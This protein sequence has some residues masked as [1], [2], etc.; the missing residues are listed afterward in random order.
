MP[1]ERVTA[2]QFRET[3]RRE[4]LSRADDYDVGFGPIR[5]IVIDPVASVLEQQNDRIREVSL[6]ISLLNPD[7]LDD[8]DVDAFVANEGLRRIQGSRAVTN[9]TFF[10]TTVD[11]SGP[12][13]VVQQGY[14][15]ATRPDQQTGETITFVTTE[16]ATLVVA[17]ASSFFNIDTQRFELTVPARATVGGTIGNVAS[18]RI[19]R[20]LRPLVGFAGVTNVR[21]ST[22]GRGRETNR[23][24]IERYLLTVRGTDISTAT[25]VQRFIRNRFPTVTDT[26]VVF[27]N[28]PLLTRA[29][30]TTGAV[31]VY[32]Q[33]SQ[34][35]TRTEIVEFVGL[36]Q[37]IP[38]SFPPVQSVVSVTS[39]ATTY[40]EG[41]DFVVV[42]DTT[43]NSGSTRGSDGIR[44]LSTASSPPAGGDAVT[45]VYASNQ[46]VRDIQNL[47]DDDDQRVFGRDLLVRRGQDVPVIIEARLRVEA[48]FN[49]S[50]VTGAVQSALLD[51]VNGLQFGANVEESDLQGEVRR[52]TGVDNFLIDRL[53]RSSVATGAAD[54]VINDNEFASL[55]AANITITQI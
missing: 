33:G 21:P 47:L 4:I 49:G 30:A 9:L 13:I 3:L 25:G 8:E 23:Q 53:V 15:V 29:D 28:N 12:D 52:V 16:P 10:T 39:G 1:V 37:F 24:L 17:S 26:A 43:D 7:S 51:F 22:G 42:Q 11:T 45:V 32:I 31:D 19:Q 46:L 18:N 5:D 36:N 27:G 50:T 48:G 44:F 55:S 34:S 35:V 40:V 2:A 54:I 14:P 41:A 38:L 20:T 6:L